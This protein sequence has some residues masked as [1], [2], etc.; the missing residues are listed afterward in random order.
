M[1]SVATLKTSRWGPM[2]RY[3]SLSFRTELDAPY[4]SLGIPPP[5]SPHYHQPILSQAALRS[6][7]GSSEVAFFRLRQSSGTGVDEPPRLSVVHSYKGHCRQQILQP[8]G[9]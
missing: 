7:W 8:P 5:C 2:E 4:W 1:T 3:G 9:L 6:R